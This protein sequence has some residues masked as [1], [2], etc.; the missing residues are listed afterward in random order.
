MKR[1]T[2]PTLVLA[3]SIV[4]LA[5]SRTFAQ[6]P[7]FRSGV[8]VVVVDVLVTN[9]GRPV[10]GLK[11]DD[12]ELR[13]NGVA[14]KVDLSTLAGNVNV[15]LALDTSGSLAGEKLTSLK[16]ASRSLIAALRP[17]D[18]ASLLSFSHPIELLAAAERDPSVV[19]RVLDT[20]SAGGRTALLDAL[21][22]AITV[23]DAETPRSLIILFSDGGENASWLSRE[24]VFDSLK[25]ASVVIYSVGTTTESVP[26]GE[27]LMAKIAEESGGT[28]L[29]AEA[30]RKL[31]GVFVGILNEFRMR[32]LLT[33]TPTGVKRGDGWHRISVKVKAKPGRVT[34]RPGYF[35]RVTAGPT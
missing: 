22:T 31:P 18:T 26:F 33:Y 12:F 16:N 6:K 2:W 7:Q 35:A 10:E 27:S 25:H 1:F 17:G 14:Q 19:D 29:H 20:V 28:L 9:H 13:D 21:Y 3:A 5:G 11:A 30:D 24:S 4:I 8:D 34:A 15:V 32:Y 23:T